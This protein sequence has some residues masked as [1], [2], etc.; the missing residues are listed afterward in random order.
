M[1]NMNTNPVYRNASITR[2]EMPKGSLFWVALSLV[3]TIGSAIP[4]QYHLSKGTSECLYAS[5]SHNEHITTSIFITSGESLRAVTT[6]QGPI[7]QRTISS[8][9]EVLAAAMRLDK[10]GKDKNALKLNQVF[11]IDFEN[12]FNDDEILHDDDWKDDDES[13]KNAQ[14]DLDDVILQDYYYMDDDDEYAFMIDDAMDD[15][16][17]SEIRAA[18]AARDAMTP[19]QK[20]QKD[21][22]KKEAR[23]KKLEALRSEM[24]AKL[25]QKKEEM[26]KKRQRM[27]DEKKKELQKMNEGKPV[28][29]TFMVDEDGWYRFCVDAK[30]AAIELEFD[31]R[32]STEL[33]QPNQKTG[34]IQTYERHDMLMNE[35]KLMAKLDANAKLAEG[36]VKEEDLKTTKDQI[37]KMNRLL[38]EIREKQVNERHRLGVHKAVNEHSHSRM[39][40]GSL[41]ETVCYI[42][43]S[44]FQ[45][46]TIRRWFS[47]NPILAY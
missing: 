4:V 37:A 47:G 29:K 44:G 20:L 21:Q 16:E 33:G 11:D 34:H 2:T 7:A 22:E 36:F 23:K 10:L 31:L 8:S 45:V 14:A 1:V 43:I 3:L 27:V 25:E 5:L 42:V 24:K 32:T 46:Y 13:I 9:A 30:Y 19:E 35:K 26:R 17:I 38:N 40:V 6:L 18:K 28:E 39:V 41:F 12:L 15:A